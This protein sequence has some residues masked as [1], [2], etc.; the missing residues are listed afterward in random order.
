[1][2]KVR[3]TFIPQ[4]DGFLNWG[5]DESHPWPSPSTSNFYH[6]F[7]RELQGNPAFVT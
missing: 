2:S 6:A 5:V 7:P 1:M 4:D 3:R